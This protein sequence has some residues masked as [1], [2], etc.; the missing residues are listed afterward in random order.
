MRVAFVRGA[1][2]AAALA[3]KDF[4]RGEAPDWF[5]RLIGARNSVSVLPVVMED[6]KLGDI[7]IASNPADGATGNPAEWTI[8]NP[9]MQQINA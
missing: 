2:P 6:R 5:F 4:A 1:D 9:A 7:V 3:P 8:R